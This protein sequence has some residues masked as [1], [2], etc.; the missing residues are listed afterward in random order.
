MHRAQL[1]VEEWQYEALR[2]IAEHEK[3][4]ISGV[5]RDILTRHL[6]NDRGKPESRLSTIEGIGADTES[7]GRDHDAWLYQPRRRK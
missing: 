5:L 7:T 1:I 2:S 3:R 4:S 6:Q